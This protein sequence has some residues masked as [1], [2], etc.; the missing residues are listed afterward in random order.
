ML[1]NGDAKASRDRARRARLWRS[2][3]LRRCLAS[4]CKQTE[5]QRLDELRLVALETQMTPTI[6]PESTRSSSRLEGL[7]PNTLR[8]RFRAQLMVAL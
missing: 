6:L 2:P 3:R 8:E 4:R 1:D 7:S 5:P